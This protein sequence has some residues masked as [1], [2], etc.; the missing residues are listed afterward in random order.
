MS[1]IV[2]EHRQYLQ[3]A[4]R[5]GA[6][7]AAIERCVRPGDVV[8]DFGAGTGIL[9]LLAC[10]A[11]AGRVYALESTGIIEIARR[12]ARASGCADRMVY[13]NQHSRTAALPERADGVVMDQI[14]R[15]GF[16]A[17]L[18]EYMADARRFLKPDA[19]TIPQ[20]IDF[21]VAPVSD[22]ELRER[23]E[24]WRRPLHDLDLSPAREWAAN[25]GYPK[26]IEE[27]QLLGPAA[28][29][30]TVQARD[31]SSQRFVMRATL[32][33]SREGMLDAIGGWFHAML[34]PGIPLT[35]GPGAEARLSRRNVLLPI[36][37]PVRVVPGDIVEVRLQALPEDSLLTWRGTVRTA[38]GT[39]SFA[40]STLSGMLF[41]RDDVRRLKPSDA[42][43]L[44]ERGKA[45]LTVLRLCDGSRALRQVEQE[46][47]AQ[48]PGLFRS[49]ADAAVF[50]SEVVSRYTE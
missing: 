3:D 9:G 17:G 1:L 38:S 32:T 44:T 39:T 10:Q 13:V 29:A 14:G 46:V 8:V 27:E 21:C 37:Q 47:F 36:D 33:V 18:F 25:T 42:P 19:W 23:I 24:F 43:R 15:F 50:V 20:A 48:H 28:V 35:N 30:A 40:H 49:E 45:R 34:A 41:T 11:G 31:M 12:I 4:V 2:D 26:H 16:E 7:R 6:F 22:A 5:I